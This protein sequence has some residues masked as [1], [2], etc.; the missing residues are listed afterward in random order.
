M[1]LGRSIHD[2]ALEISRQ[3]AAATD[4]VCQ[5]AGVDF[6]EVDGDVLVGAGGWNYPATPLA[7][8]Q[9]GERHKIPAR[10][11]DRL[12]QDYP[13]LLAETLNRIG[14]KEP[15]RRLVRTLDGSV[16]AYLSDRYRTLDNWEVAEHALP[17]IQEATSGTLEFASTE[18]TDTRLYLKALM[19]ELQAEVRN[20]GDVVQG[21]ISITNSECGL[22]A[23]QARQLVLTL[24]C[25][26]GMVLP[27]STYRRTHLG[28]ELD[29]GQQFHSV[30]TQRLTNSAVMAQLADVIRG[31]LSEER[32]TAAVNRLGD[33]TERHL[34]GRPQNAV[35]QVAQRF[36][37]NENE[38]DG[39]LN[40]LIRG[41]DM[42]QYGLH[43]AV[44]RA[45]QDVQ[46]Y[47]RASD[48]ETMGGKIIELRSQ[49]WEVIATA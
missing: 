22:S 44:T 11:Y 29:D 30:Q 34:T 43:A 27:D 41:G 20:V 35:E 37:L 9:I 45:S 4:Y 28:R 47:D 25:E 49:D 48:L 1:K 7:H 8:R 14:Q 32:F 46:D 17:A 6:N 24:R 5:S 23:L 3:K 21:G 39:V 15:S 26:N 12:R 19:P 2:V 40:H 16:R 42:T 10:H 13:D 33:S 38:S 18:V 36:D 31:M